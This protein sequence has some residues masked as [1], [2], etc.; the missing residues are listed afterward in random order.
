[1]PVPITRIVPEFNTVRLFRNVTCGTNSGTICRP[2]QRS[3]PGPDDRAIATGCAKGLASGDG[4]TME[5]AG[6]AR[7]AAGA[8]PRAGRPR[9]GRGPAAHP[10][11]RTADVDRGSRRAERVPLLRGGLRPARVR[12]GREGRP[13]R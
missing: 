9:P 2:V 8:V 12:Q 4:T 13:D 1:M 3:G 6:V 7:P 5:L 11:R 10:R